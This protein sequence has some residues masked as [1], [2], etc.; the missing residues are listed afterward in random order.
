VRSTSQSSL[1][2][3]QLKNGIAV[4]LARKNE[5]IP[6][7]PA[8]YILVLLLTFARWPSDP[9]SKIAALSSNAMVVTWS[10]IPIQGRSLENQRQTHSRIIRIWKAHADRVRVAKF[11]PDGTRMVSASDDQTARIWDVLSGKL[12]ATCTGH[13]GV[14]FD[15]EFSHDGKDVL[16]ISEDGTARI[17]QAGTGNPLVTFQENDEYILFAFFLPDH[18]HCSERQR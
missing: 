5:I 14:I 17:W 13:K 1:G 3:R 12:I 7:K 4:G 8:L 6:M 11:S 18:N 16:T 2:N 15:A 9:A 10:G